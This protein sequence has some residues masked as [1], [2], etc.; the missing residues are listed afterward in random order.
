MKSDRKRSRTPSESEIAPQDDRVP[1]QAP[2]VL[3]VTSDPE[4]IECGGARKLYVVLERAQL[5][6]VKIGKRFELLNSDDHAAVLKRSGRDIGSSRPDI[7]HQ[8]LLMLMDSPLNRAGLLQVF[9]H[10]EQ[11]VLIEVHPQTRIPR[12]FRRFCNLFVQLL[13][14]MCIRAEEGG[15]KLL[16]TVKNPVSDHL[17]VGASR[18]CLS[19]GA[20]QM[21]RP[22]Q[23]A[24]SRGPVTLVIGAMAHGSVDVD[25]VEFSRSISGYPLS[26]AL[27]CSKVCDGFEQAWGI[28]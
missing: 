6:T 23:L 5:E 17:P 18:V 19:F 1:P 3:D 27:A 8:C 16:K 21:C 20:S 9:I 22:R 26:G 15:L 25:Y 28:H 24:P 11:N 12:T 4:L 2:G 7:T 14:K 10:T 13:H